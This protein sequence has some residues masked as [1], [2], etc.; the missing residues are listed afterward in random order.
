MKVMITHKRSKK[1][2]YMSD[3]V[4]VWIM[5]AGTEF[6]YRL[7]RKYERDGETVTEESAF[8]G[9]EYALTEVYDEK[10]WMI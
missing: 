10:E 6:I 7:K 8:H 1:E 9:S 3:V 5:N 2:Y 4:R